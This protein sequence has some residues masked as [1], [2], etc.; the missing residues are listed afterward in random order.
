MHYRVKGA[1]FS[2]PYFASDSYTLKAG[3]DRADTVLLEHVKAQP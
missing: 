2:A 1:E 3:A